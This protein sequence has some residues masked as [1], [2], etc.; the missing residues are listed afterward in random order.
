[1]IRS[2][3]QT[4]QR[5]CAYAFHHSRV[6]NPSQNK[7]IKKGAGRIQEEDRACERNGV[8]T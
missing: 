5:T 6:K 7:G 2:P 4:P 3:R 8:L 1:M